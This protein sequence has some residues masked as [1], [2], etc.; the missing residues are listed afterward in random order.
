MEFVPGLVSVI[1]ANYN[2]P[3]EYLRESIDSILAQTYGDFEFII[4]DDASTDGSAKTVGSYNDPRI[5]LIHNAENL[6]LTKSLNKALDVCRGE[7]IARMDSDDVSEPTRFE[8]QVSFLR[9]NPDVIVCGTWA[10]LF[11]DW[12]DHNSNE[13]LCRSI[14]DRETFRIF[15]LFG[16]NPNIVH[17]SAMFS[18]KLMDENNVRYN[19]NYRYAQDYRMWVSC[20][21]AA[22]CAIIP[23]ILVNIRVREGTISTAKKQEQDNCALGII[24]EQL[25]SLDLKL[26]E[27]IKPLHYL[28]LTSRKPYDARLKAWIKTLISA[29]RKRRVYDRKLFEEL[30]WKKWAETCYFALHDKNAFRRIGVIFDIP[31]LFWPELFRIRR[32]RSKR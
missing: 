22:K 15:Q 31:P 17:I 1:M 29:N 9:E 2:T 32:S 6:G 23:E 27:E 4:V 16:N 19:E 18:K 11:G 26:P 12:A 20:N 25:D 5:R 30:L 13:T 10:R 24:Q 8:K 7:F 3:A 14:P 28:L 21:S